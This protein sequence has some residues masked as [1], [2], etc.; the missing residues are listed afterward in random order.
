PNWLN[1]LGTDVII[2]GGMGQR[3]VSLFGEKGIKVITGAPEL[4]PE[5]LVTSYLDNT[6]MAGANICDH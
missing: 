5:P 4:E 3:A 6:L 1:E 2:A